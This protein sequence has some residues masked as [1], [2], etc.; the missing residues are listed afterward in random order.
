[1]RP[2]HAPM[3]HVLHDK[4][5]VCA[6]DIEIMMPFWILQQQVSL[7]MCSICRR[8]RCRTAVCAEV[9]TKRTTCVESGDGDNS[10]TSW[11]GLSGHQS[12]QRGHNGCSS[13]HRV[14]RQMGHG[15]VPTSAPDRHPEPVRS[16]H[17]RSRL[18]MHHPEVIT[19]SCAAVSQLQFTAQL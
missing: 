13:D 14:C 3:L 19:S 5:D 7:Q 17:E 6:S 15:S 8:S 11:R 16:C 2:W 12:L 1:M 10:A 4:G 9:I 18:H